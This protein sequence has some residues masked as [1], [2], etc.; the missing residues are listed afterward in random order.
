[1]SG[2]MNSLRHNAAVVSTADNVCR[3]RLQIA[4]IVFVALGGMAC[5]RAEPSGAANSS[6]SSGELTIS[7][8]ASLKDAFGEIKKLHEARTG[9]KINFNY[10]ASG[11]LQKQI[12]TGAPVD[13][14]ASAGRPQMDALAS[15]ALIVAETQKDFAR[16]SLV[17]VV[18]A[19]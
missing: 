16:N 7:A 6:Q 11:A 13:V 3:K 19:D 10:G 1:M 8:A 4:L 12:E 15:K 2:F 14:F 18:P 5:R 17:L 9:T